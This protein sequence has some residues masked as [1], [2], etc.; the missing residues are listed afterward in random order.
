MNFQ[1]LFSRFRFKV[2]PLCV[3]RK[4]IV[5]WYTSYHAQT[6]ATR[7]FKWNCRVFNWSTRKRLSCKNSK[8]TFCLDGR[9]VG[10]SP[11]FLGIGNCV[12]FQNYQFYFWFQEIETSFSGWCLY[13]GCRR[14][15][16]ATL[17]NSIQKS[18]F[19]S[20]FLFFIENGI[21]FKGSR[22]IKVFDVLGSVRVLCMY[23]P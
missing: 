4:S 16:S 5:P 22:G 17:K 20:F 14:V 9:D 10:L 8:K 12:L 15:H 18:C 19:F 2:L 1:S 6:N 13:L 3:G 23:M 11:V 7:N 21:K